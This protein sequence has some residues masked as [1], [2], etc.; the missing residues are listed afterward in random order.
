M[1]KLT[2]CRTIHCIGIGGIGLSAIAEILL[3][4]GIS[5]TGSDLKE[6][7]MTDKL[8]ALGAKIFIGHR[9]QNVEGA[10]LVIYSAAIAD[11]NP[12]II[13]AKELNIPLASRA[14]ILGLLMDEYPVG[15]AISGTHGK[16]TT[17]SMVSLI[18]E[19]AGK[20]PTVLIGGNLS[21]FNGNCKV[22]SGRYFV[23]EACEYRDSFLQ[24]RPN[25]EVI[26]N[27]DSD[28]LDYFKDIDHIVKSFDRFSKNLKQGGTIVAYSANPF[29]NSIIKDMDE[30]VTYGFG[31]DCTYS[32]SNVEI[33][34][35]GRPAFDV[36]RRGK[37]LGHLYLNL[38]GEHY[39]LNATAAFAC[40]SELGVEPDVIIKALEEYH[41]T[42]RRFD[43]IGYTPSGAMI[44][45]DYGHHPT[46]I[47]AT[48]KA[49]SQMKHN[50]IWCI[51]QPHTYTRTLALLDDFSDAFDNADV[52]ILA[53]I[54]A[55]RESDIYNISSK[56]LLERIKER[57]PGKEAYYMSS[58]EEIA[59]KVSKE[60]KEGDVI[61][62]QGAGDIYKVG[63]MLLDG[64]R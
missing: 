24:L 64:R 60:A 61:I 5:V 19:R 43:K 22:G 57:H 6:S 23:T 16:T 46:E 62:T 40:A 20:D 37:K 26:L 28:H 27:I 1:V 50:R 15:I 59:D 7:E 14:E 48:L 42:D 3:Q 38:P 52:L 30:I 21:E 47:R 54:Y 58:F 31:S 13:R 33:S 35:N 56:N 53:D 49:A 9:A 45:D 17:T 44:I 41:G 25:V 18:L 8:A 51:F 12:E 39:I 10:D 36:S 11:D 2:D 34:D 29:V 4:R 32:I 63:K 55:A